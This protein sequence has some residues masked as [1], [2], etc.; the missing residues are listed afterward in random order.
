M[1]DIDPQ[2]IVLGATSLMLSSALI[3]TLVLLSKTKPP[4]DI[5]WLNALEEEF[6]NDVKTSNMEGASHE[7]ELMAM[8]GSLATLKSCFECARARIT[9]SPE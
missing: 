6:I 9:G 3:D 8:N 5:S 2:K 4:N 1:R 7:L